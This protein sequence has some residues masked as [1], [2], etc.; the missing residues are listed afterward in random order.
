MAFVM[1]KWTWLD[2]TD[3]TS[4][5]ISD[6][7]GDASPRND[8]DLT[9]DEIGSDEP[10]TDEVPTI[11]H[12]VV[13]K[14]IG[15]H[16][17]H[18]YQELLSLANK[19]IKDGSTV[20]VKLQPEPDN[21]FD[22]KA[23]AIMTTIEDK[24]ERIGYIVKEALHDVHEAINNDKILSVSFAWIKYIVYFK[25]PGWYAGIKITRNG[26]WSNHVL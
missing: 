5:S 24:W 1:W 17:E 20:P 3:C 4:P 26:E 22:C 21:Q 10:I 19:K 8:V 18:H 25:C 15:S 9:S 11:T 14:C 16:K 13:F 23:I 12:S 2:P 7:E 6:S